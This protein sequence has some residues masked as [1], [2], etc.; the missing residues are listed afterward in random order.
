[1]RFYA[2]SPSLRDRILAELILSGPLGVDAFTLALR[3]G[4][5]TEDVEAMLKALVD[6]GWAAQVAVGVR[7]VDSPASR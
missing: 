1:M 7:S 4:A 5:R 3:L 6:G 2:V